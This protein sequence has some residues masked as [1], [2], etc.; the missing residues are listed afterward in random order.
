VKVLGEAIGR[1]EEVDEVLRDVE[2]FDGADAEAFDRG[3]VENAA[4]E[5]FEFDAGGK[6]AAVG[7]EVDPAEDDFAV[8]RLAEVVYFPDD[9]VRWQA[10]APPANKR[11]HAIGAAGVAA[12]LDFERGTGVIPFTAE[13]GGGEKFGAVEDVAGEDLAEKGRSML[14]ACKGMSRNS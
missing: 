9:C 7:A 3:F 6:I 8:S 13:D 11:D 10:A 12:V 1:S 4:K 14:R 2:R 5:V